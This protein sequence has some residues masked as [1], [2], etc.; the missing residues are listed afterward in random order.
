[1]AKQE[2]MLAWATRLID[3]DIPQGIHALG[4]PDGK[5]CCLGVLCD[6]AVEAGVIDPPTV[7]NTGDADRPTYEL[8]YDGQHVYLPISVQSWAGLDS[9]DPVL[10]DCPDDDHRH[11]QCDETGSQMNDRHVPFVQIGETIRRKFG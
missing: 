6:M 4:T 1:M 2:I 9:A 3:G 7:V 11:V 5:R 10:V 8:S